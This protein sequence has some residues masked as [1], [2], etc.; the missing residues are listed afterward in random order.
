MFYADCLRYNFN[1][2]G[3]NVLIVIKFP[4]CI[5]ISGEC[6]QTQDMVLFASSLN[7]TK[8]GIDCGGIYIR[9]R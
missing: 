7:Y 9:S 6:L 2:I 3:T 4:T 1:Q 5:V 8:L